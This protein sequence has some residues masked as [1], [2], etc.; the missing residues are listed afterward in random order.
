MAIST[1]RI[2][3]PIQGLDFN[4]IKSNLIQFLKTDAHYTDYNFEGSGITALLN[5]LA[6][7]TH[8]IG[9][10]VKMLLGESFV[11][12]AV[13]RESLMSMSKLNGYL[14]KNKRCSRASVILKTTMLEN[15]E[16]ISQSLTIPRGSS[17]LGHNN[18]NDA[19]SF[20][21]LDEVI[22]YT[23]E[24]VAPNSLIYTSPEMAVYEGKMKNWRFKVNTGIENQRFIIKDSKIDTD[25]IRVTVFDDDS[26]V[27]GE[28]F[29]IASNLFEINDNSNVFYISTNELGYYE[30]FFGNNQ[31][32]VQPAHN[33]IIYVTYIA[34]NGSTGNGC[35]ELIYQ[36]PAEDL[37]TRQT[38]GSFDNFQTIMTHPVS[39]GGVDEE[40]IDS[41][42]FN[43]PNHF[44]LQGRAVTENDYKSILMT[45]FRDIDSVNVWGGEKNYYK[46]FGSVY[47][48][49]KPKYSRT[50][51]GFAKEEIAKLLEKFGVIGTRIIVENPDY[52]DV[53][54]DFY[55]QYDKNATDKSFGEIESIV[56]DAAVEFNETYLN[57]FDSGLSDIDL[58]DFIKTKEG[59][60]NRIYDKKVISKTKTIVYDSTTE[61]L[62]LFGNALVPK[63]ITTNTLTYGTTACHI[64]DDGIGS[65]WFV[66][67]N[68]VKKISTP[69][70]SVDYVT[71]DVKVKLEIDFVSN[72]G[73]DGIS[74]DVVFSAIPQIPDI[75]T[76]LNNIVNI[77][78]VRA[79][80]S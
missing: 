35:K 2:N 1:N 6:F 68:N 21:V 75:N 11:D 80:I 37:Q 48:S 36:K 34:S 27:N 39:F 17:F 28:K 61:N 79:F 55:V 73:N 18:A 25:T 40:S 44:R 74:G 67:S 43:I 70:G 50:L 66:N 71:G 10:Y 23:K 53:A 62:I 58:L 4:E 12:S 59:S 9:F 16:P 63:S 20:Y 14:P 8:Y 38:T 26:E 42:R 47:V 49:I 5:I 78:S 64:I 65:L 51:S 32:G 30:L 29:N 7:N 69:I 52:V 15:Q 77:S 76:Y 13:K 46:D 60:I 45:E 22:C 56:I 33:N 41:L 72:K 19:R 31:Y 24:E 3:L 54:I 57:T